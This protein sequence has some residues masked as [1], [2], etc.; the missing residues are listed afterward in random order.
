MRVRYK[1][2]VNCSKWRN[3]GTYSG[4]DYVRGVRRRGIMICFSAENK[5]VPLIYR[6]PR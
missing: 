1:I 3:W 5:W 4:C 2:I 6:W